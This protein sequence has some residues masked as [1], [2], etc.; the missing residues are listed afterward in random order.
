MSGFLKLRYTLL[1]MLS[2]PATLYGIPCAFWGWKGTRQ[3]LML[4]DEHNP[5]RVIEFDGMTQFGANV[6]REHL[7]QNAF[8]VDI[9][10]DRAIITYQRDDRS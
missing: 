3:F 4:G 5:T 2:V 8:L 9:Q 10:Q 7:L 1:G 6:L